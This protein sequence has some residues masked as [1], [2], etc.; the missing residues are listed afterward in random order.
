MLFEILGTFAGYHHRKWKKIAVILGIAFFFGVLGSF[1][2]ILIDSP[3]TEM[4]NYVIIPIPINLVLF[5]EWTPVA[6]SG[7]VFSEAVLIGLLSVLITFVY[8]LIGK[9]AK[10]FLSKR[11]W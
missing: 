7:S 11:G 1:L 10:K 4:I 9:L 6:F 5:V 2:K 8:W 3:A